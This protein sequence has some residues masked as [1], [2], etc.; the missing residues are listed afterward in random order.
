MDHGRVASGAKLS[1]IVGPEL[2]FTLNRTLA[3]TFAPSP[4]A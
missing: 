2:A 1:S 3:A 4:L